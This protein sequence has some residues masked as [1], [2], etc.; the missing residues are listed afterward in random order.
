MA[1]LYEFQEK[2][3]L[4]RQKIDN[5]IITNHIKISRISNQGNLS[6]FWMRPNREVIQWEHRDTLI[7]VINMKPKN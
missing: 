4:S 3:L 6:N 5:I 7:E 2:H 1:N